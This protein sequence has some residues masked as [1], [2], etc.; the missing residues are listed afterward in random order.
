M[1]HGADG[2]QEVEGDALEVVADGLRQEVGDDVLPRVVGDVLPRVV[3]M[4]GDDHLPEDAPQCYLLQVEDDGQL[5]C[6][7]GPV[8]YPGGL[9]TQ[10][11]NQPIDPIIHQISFFAFRCKVPSIVENVPD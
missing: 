7:E 1:H 6:L 2:L 11:S 4:G 9:L 8:D 5:H 3:E 10:P